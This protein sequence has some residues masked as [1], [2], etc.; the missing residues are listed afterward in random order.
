MYFCMKYK[1][2]ER[3]WENKHG[4]L[5]VNVESQRHECARK[6]IDNELPMCL[7]SEEQGLWQIF[8]LIDEIYLFCLQNLWTPSCGLTDTS[9]RNQRRWLVTL[10]PSAGY[11]GQLPF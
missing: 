2:I 11:T 4:T 8:A 9:P 1:D 10:E 6:G 5:D 3:Q 7:F